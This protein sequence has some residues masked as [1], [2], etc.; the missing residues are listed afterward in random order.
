M[1]IA[2]MVS[3][4]YFPYK[5][6]FGTLFRTLPIAGSLSPV[7]LDLLAEGDWRQ[8]EAKIAEAAAILLAQQN[9]LGITPAI[10]MQTETVDDGRHHV[11]GDYGG[12][13]R[14][15]AEHVRPPLKAVIENQVF[16]LHERNLILWNEEVGKWSLL[17]Q[18]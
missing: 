15:I 7:L 18:K 8:V 13:G 4:R 2:Y 5:K 6:W 11:S 3:R 14:S 16:W 9:E 17:L 1:R 12:I 10:S